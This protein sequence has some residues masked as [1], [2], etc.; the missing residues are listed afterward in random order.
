MKRL[1][2]VPI[3]GVLFI[4]L[5]VSLV[6]AQAET[7][8]E[9]VDRALTA[10]NTICDTLG[11]NEACYGNDRLRAELQDDTSFTKPADKVSIGDIH[12]IRTFGL[13]ENNGTWG[14]VVM[15]VLANLPQTLPGQGVKFILYGDVALE[16]ASNSDSPEISP[17]QAF[18]FTTNPFKP[19]C[20]QAPTD[21]LVIQSPEGYRVNLSAN[22][23]DLD[24]GSS[25]VLSAQRG[26]RMM[27][28]TLHGKVYATY[29]GKKQI[30][31][32]GF[33]T[34]VALGGTNGLTPEDAPSTAYLI[35]S[36]E[37]ESLAKATHGLTD[38]DIIVPDTS[39]WKSVEDYCADPAN[40]DVCA[41]P[42]L[43]SELTF[44]ECPADVCAPLTD[45]P[46]DGRPTDATC[47]DLF[48]DPAPQS[49][50]TPEAAPT[51]DS[52]TCASGGITITIEP[53]VSAETVNNAE[54][55]AAPPVECTEN[56][57]G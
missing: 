56:C 18:Y 21:S 52:G 40:A 43:K 17:M 35:D 55:T 27:L 48:C 12:T 4:I 20:E 8:P 57:G 44:S 9:L 16:N 6:L 30:I 24:V 47:A 34:S 14:I 10:V 28:T 39:K 2:S 33:E 11:R 29:K 37:W 13:D 5:S 31:P 45:L 7:C 23:L 51:C 3:F 54:P 22:G 46:P 19:Q 15:N 49:E 32:Q 26:K 25:V 50:Q 42:T 38:T 36:T 53:T 1:M 41:D